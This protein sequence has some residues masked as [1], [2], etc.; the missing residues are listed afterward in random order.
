MKKSVFKVD[1]ST[2]NIAKDALLFSLP[3]LFSGWLQL[4]Y[5]AA[6]LIVCGQFGS[7]YSV[8]AIAATNSL[9]SLIV[10]LFLG[11]SVGANVLMATAFGGKLKDKST[12]IIGTTY[13]L[14]IASGI[15]LAVVGVTCSRYFLKAMGTP[16]EIIE[17][18]NTY[19]MIY[20]VGIPFT[21]IF[22]FGSAL[23]RGMGETFKPFLFL[24]FAGAVNVSLNFLFVITFHMDVAGVATTTVIAQAISAILVTIS[25]LTSKSL[26]A[27]L[28]IK[29]IRFHKDETIGIIRIGVPAGIQSALFSLSNVILQSSINSF[30]PDAVTG[31]GAE[32]SIESFMSTGVDAFAQ[33]SVAF[34]GANYG[35]KNIQRVK[36]SIFIISL[37]GLIFT[38]IMATFAY[39][40][41]ESLLR[42]YIQDPVAISYGAEKL[43]LVSA[44]YT[45]YALMSTISCAIRGFG[46]SITPMIVSLM[47]ICVLRIVYIYTLFPLPEL[48]SIF[49]LYISY[50]L[51]WAATLLA[52]LICFFPLS[53]KAFAKIQPAE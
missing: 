22:N 42:I 44:T 24:A 50:P 5:N 40:M 33:A 9:T 47:G 8:G 1:M 34:V 31:A 41:A 26:F 38:A 3:I 29:S 39:F 7:K 48:H 46:Y 11:F 21:L 6:D 12:R 2:G 14:A 53:K 37:Y 20:F 30:G 27:N 18:S 15:I 16:D 32:S 52:H 43:H 17:L 51:S 13:A 25:L 45:V 10:S 4:L 19:M 28:R 49:G 23:L 36:K 35:A